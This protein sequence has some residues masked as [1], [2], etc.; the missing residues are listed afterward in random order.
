MLILGALLEELPK[1]LAKVAA[2]GLNGGRWSDHA[3][4]PQMRRLSGLRAESLQSA[5]DLQ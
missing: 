5:G 3:L 1:A 4:C 2:A